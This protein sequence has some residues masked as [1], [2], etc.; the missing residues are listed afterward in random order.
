MNKKALIAIIVVVG[1]LAAGTL[2]FT[3]VKDILIKRDPVNHLLYSMTKSS[4][5]AV[6]ASYSGKIGVEKDMLTESF[7]YFV[8]EPEAMAEFVS[9]LIS[10]VTFSGDI[11]MKA[12]VKSKEMFLL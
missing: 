1:V 2:G 11:V 12:D 5:E 4:Y 6:D 7:T 8:D 9:S 10:E 3:V